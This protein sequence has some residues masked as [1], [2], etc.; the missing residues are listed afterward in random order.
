MIFQDIPKLSFLSSPSS[1]LP[2]SLY[3][4][5][6]IAPAVDL[7]SLPIFRVQPYDLMFDFYRD[8]NRI[9]CSDGDSDDSNQENHYGNEYPDSDGSGTGER[10]MR[11]ALEAM[12]LQQEE[13]MDSSDDE[14]F[15]EEETLKN[16]GGY[17]H[18][19]EV[20]EPGFVGDEDFQDTA[21]RY[22]LAYAK[23]KKK[24]LKAFANAKEVPT[25]DEEDEERSSGGS[26]GYFGGTRSDDDVE[27]CFS[28]NEL[29]K[30][31]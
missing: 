17:V 25:D 4:H 22:G 9:E 14:D 21:D 27:D 23:Y 7:Y 6:R 5:I 1:R 30:Y 31:A 28:E 15:Y 10:A 3:H 19:L 11:H 18:T 24:I 2:T 8:P 12:Q 13:E 29:D 16:A 26:G 20:D